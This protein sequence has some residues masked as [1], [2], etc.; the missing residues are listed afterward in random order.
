MRH[1]PSQTRA[2]GNAGVLMRH[3]KIGWV[4]LITLTAAVL[5]GCETDG[6]SSGPIAGLAVNSAK[7]EEPPE[8]PMT[9]SQAAMECWMKTEK[10]RADENLDKRADI[11]TKCIDEKVKPAQAAPKS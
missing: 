3:R 5:S 1:P 11:V 10:A 6:T 2:L 9:R 8:P 4:A 7:K